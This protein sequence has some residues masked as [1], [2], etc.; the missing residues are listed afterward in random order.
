MKRNLFLTALSLL[1]LMQF[2]HA[3]LKQGSY[4]GGANISSSWGSITTNPFDKSKFILG[5]TPSVGYFI[6]DKMV[7]GVSTPIQ[8]IRPAGINTG[9]FGFSPF[10]RMYFGD[11]KYV[12]FFMV[13]KA[14]YNDLSKLILG[15][16]LPTQNGTAYFGGGVAFFFSKE[17]AVEGLLKYEGTYSENSL[18]ASSVGGEIGIQYYFSTGGTKKKK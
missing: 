12:K 11:Y 6:S 9:V 14:G 2:S 13:G 17:L 16:Q 4:M 3:Q 5:I 7:L 15:T 1:V 8:I 18:P 10:F